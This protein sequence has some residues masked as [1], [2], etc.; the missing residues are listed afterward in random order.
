MTPAQPKRTIAAAGQ[1]AEGHLRRMCCEECFTD[2]VLKDF[3][4]ENGE[5]GDCEYCDARSVNCVAPWDLEDLFEPVIGLYEIAEYGVH[6]GPDSNSSPM[7][8]PLLFHLENDWEEIFS[9]HLGRDTRSAILS[10]IVYALTGDRKDPGLNVNDLWV[11]RSSAFLHRSPSEY[12]I[13]FAH[14]ITH[15]RRF[16]P[17]LNDDLGSIVD[18]VPIITKALDLVDSRLP[19][20][21]AIYRAREGGADGSSD[22]PK[23]A[24]DMGAPP[25]NQ[26]SGGRA[27]PPGM[28]F[29]YTA[30]DKATAVAEIRPWKGALVTVAKFVLPAELRI[31]DLLA[32]PEFESPFGVPDL[33]D[34]VDR[35]ALLRQLASELMK[36][37]APGTS[38]VDYVPTQYLSEVI[39]NAGFDGIKYPSALGLDANLVV[40]DPKPFTAESV[41]LVEVADVQYK[42]K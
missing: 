21:T 5:L 22:Q 18:P 17:D 14:H 33:S 24:K 25:R 38:D 34:Q 31:A 8:E 35:R 42:I 40:F 39:R 30:F 27:N 23:A 7:G 28:P 9:E 37:V 36:P 12:W 3:I 15:E 1:M 20:G 32:I 19:A 11:D 4:R 13:E 6:F 16:I 2:P 41:W 10:A 26:A 29:L